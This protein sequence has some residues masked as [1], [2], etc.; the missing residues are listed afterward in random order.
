MGLANFSLLCFGCWFS[1][2]V[3]G[4]AIFIRRW[5]VAGSGKYQL[6]KNGLLG[7]WHRYFCGLQ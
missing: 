7:G 3:I 6:G 2:V 5:F 1:A 4:Y